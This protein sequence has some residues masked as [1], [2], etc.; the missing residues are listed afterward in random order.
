MQIPVVIQAGGKGTRLYPLT[1]VVPKPLVPIGG[2]PILE[3]VI[4]QLAAAGF[5]EFHI[6]IGYLGEMI[7][8]CIGDGRKWGVQV[9][10][11]EETEPLGTMGPLRQIEGLNGPCMVL[12]GDLLTNIDFASFWS[13][14][15]NSRNHLTVATYKKPVQVSLGVLDVQAD[16]RVS[17]FREKPVFEYSCSM[18]IYGLSPEALSLIPENQYYGFDD[19]MHCMLREGHPVG[20]YAFGGEWLDIGRHEDLAAACERFEQSPEL[21]LP[22]AAVAGRAA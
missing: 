9:H 15:V 10:Y 13:H 16:G 7:R 11:W 12:N 22:A 18:G 1:K 4:R 5:R 17:G 14:H 21:F 6:T 2:R 19:L 20:A 3:I 8:W